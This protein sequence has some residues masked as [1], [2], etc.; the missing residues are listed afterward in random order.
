MAERHLLEMNDEDGVVA[1][2]RA[3]RVVVVGTNAGNEDVLDL[4][5]AGPIDQGARAFDGLAVVMAGM[6]VADGDD[7]GADA[8]HV[9]AQV[10]SDGV[11]HDDDITAA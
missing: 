4:K 5:L 6:V 10:A 3:L 7:I 8:A 9:V 11:E 2:G 1:E